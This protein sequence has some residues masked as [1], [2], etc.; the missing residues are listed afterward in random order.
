M[1]AKELARIYTDVVKYEDGVDFA[2]KPTKYIERELATVANEK[3]DEIFGQLYDE[4]I[5][6]HENQ[7]RSFG[8]AFEQVRVKSN[9]VITRINNFYGYDVIDELNLFICWCCKQIVDIEKQK[10]DTSKI[11]Y[12]NKLNDVLSDP[13][14]EKII[15]PLA[16]KGERQVAR[17]KAMEN[18]VPHVIKPLREFIGEDK[19]AAISEYF[20]CLMALSQ[21]NAVGLPLSSMKSLANYITF[22]KYIID[23]TPNGEKLHI[24]EKLINEFESDR[25]TFIKKLTE[26]G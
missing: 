26:R 2:G 17:Q 22:L 5:D 6:L 9:S 4:I 7:K 10:L 21:Y 15:N 8:S 16:N 25:D 12:G 19:S 14:Y 13:K 11:K 3:L 1:N 24:D 23:T 20:A 18:F